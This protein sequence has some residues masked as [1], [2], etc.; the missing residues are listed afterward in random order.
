MIC[1]VLFALVA[2][3]PSSQQALEAMIEGNPFPSSQDSVLMEYGD[4]FLLPESP[5]LVR[6]AM[7]RQFHRMA[8]QLP[9][10]PANQLAEYINENWELFDTD[11]KNLWLEF[12]GRTG[13]D[14]PHQE[15]SSDNLTSVLRYCAESGNQPPLLD[16]GDLTD[17]T[18]LQRLYYVNSLSPDDAVG[19]M[20][21]SCWAVRNAVI[22]RNPGTAF[23]MLNDPSLY[24]R[25]NAALATG[26]SDLLIEM[27]SI[28]GPIG[29][30]SLAGVG[31]IPILEDSLYGS[32][33]RAARL[34][35]LMALFDLGW[36]VP[37]N[38]LDYLLADE[39]LVVGAVTADETGISFAE[40]PKGTLP[41]EAP[42]IN[43]VPDQI[44][45]VTDAGEFEMTLLKEEAPLTCRSFWY[46]AETGF[47]DGIY[48][49]RVIPGFVAQAGCPEGNGYGGPGYF[50]PAENNT[51]AYSR[52]VVG[53]ADSGMDT[54]G[55]QFFIMLDSQRRLDCRYTAF[56]V[57]DNPRCLDDIEIGTRILE[58]RRVNP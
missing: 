5:E 42:S 43:D 16:T 50:I 33:N 10:E 53:M 19:F 51:V 14:V 13:I 37:E 46:L 47:Y 21:D 58:I 6:F 35:A 26:R 45:L 52:G 54:G 56:A 17:L 18:D 12:A 44:L 28:E 40:P 29:H 9:G 55:S 39:Y 41:E 49:H 32:L 7:L 31:Q 3:V 4:D 2:S 11:T 57:V 36:S 30:M 34:S 24:V 20:E 8:F 27:A 23:Q 15:I 25:M 38:R 48:F 1:T 22:Q